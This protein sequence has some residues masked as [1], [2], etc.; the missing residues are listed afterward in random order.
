MHEKN[1]KDL[2]SNTTRRTVCD[3]HEIINILSRF[4]GDHRRGLYRWLDLLITLTHDSWLHF[5]VHSYTHSSV[6]FV[7]A[8]N[9][10]CLVSDSTDWDSSSFV[11]MSLLSSEYP[12][13]ELLSTDN[14]TLT[15]QLLHSDGLGF[16]MY[17]LG[18]VP[19][20][21]TPVYIV[22]VLLCASRFRGNVFS[23]PFQ[24]NA[25]SCRHHCI[26]TVL[27]VPILIIKVSLQSFKWGRYSYMLKMFVALPA[28]RSTVDFLILRLSF[29]ILYRKFC[30]DCGL[31]H[32]TTR[33]C[34]RKCTKDLRYDSV[35]QRSR[36]Y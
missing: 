21:N 26:E 3:T 5:T 20:E 19:T 25:C 33:G 13:T 12:K 10:R 4:R 22:T 8:S 14:W 34:V 15:N 28:F 35:K 18:A 30:N 17:S 9:S 29:W 24:S 23:E 11:L 2:V 7:T 1:P 16:S 32:A 27:Y 36:T 31:L 6:L